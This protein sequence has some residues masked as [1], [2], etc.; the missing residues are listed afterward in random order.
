[1][2]SELAK[3]RRLWVQENHPPHEILFTQSLDEGNPALCCKLSPNAHTNSQSAG[4]LIA[5]TIE[6]WLDA[7]IS[8]SLDLVVY[9][10]VDS[11]S[12]GRD[13]AGR[14]FCGRGVLK[15]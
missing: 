9:A 1:M 2:K 11:Y 13:H 15:G 12:S 6:K 10:T 8:F 7:S 5:A 3:R 14:V 4:C